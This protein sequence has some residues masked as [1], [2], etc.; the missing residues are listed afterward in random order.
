[1]NSTTTRYFILFKEK[2]FF[3]I[4]YVLV[5]AETIVVQGHKGVTVT[6]VGSIP[7]QGNELLFINIFISSPWYQGKARL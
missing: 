3:I 5:T 7:T 2:M 6:I 1:M 4:K